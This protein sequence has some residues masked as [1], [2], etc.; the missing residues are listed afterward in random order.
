MLGRGSLRFVGLA[1]V[2][3]A[4][5]LLAQTERHGRKYKAPPETGH[6]EVLVLRDSNGKVIENAGVIFHPSKDGIDEGNLEVKS[7]VDGKAFIDIIPVGSVVQVQVIANGFATYSG[8]L[9]LDGPSK[10]LTVRMNRPQQQISAYE[11][12]GGDSTRKLG[13]QEPSHRII[14]TP[15][16]NKAI[17][18][19]DPVI[20]LSTM[21]ADP[22]QTGD[23][24]LPADHNVKVPASTTAPKQ[25]N[26]ASA[27]TGNQGGGLGSSAPN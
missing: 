5:V 1:A 17:A 8:T 21:P 2:L 24:T 3:A 26:K 11:A 25:P 13:V 9:N 18:P 20:K 27:P 6:L 16:P 14:G 15:T 7:G 4:S 12:T 22:K 19:T 10:Q 23:P